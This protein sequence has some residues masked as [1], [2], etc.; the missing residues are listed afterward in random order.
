MQTA[1]MPSKNEAFPSKWEGGTCIDQHP[2]NPER[3]LA[4][5][6]FADW[7]TEIQRAKGYGQ[8]RL[9][10]KF[11]GHPIPHTGKEPVPKTS[12]FN[13]HLSPNP[14]W[15]EACTLPHP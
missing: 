11:L 15:L 6:H 4:D 9:K 8:P 10:I 13:P 1:F 5:P 3:G 7:N 12:R 14:C 2:N